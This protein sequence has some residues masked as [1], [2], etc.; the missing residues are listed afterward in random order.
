[1]IEPKN[2]FETKEIS[3]HRCIGDAALA[4]YYQESFIFGNFLENY[5]ERNYGELRRTTEKKLQRGG[6]CLTLS[7]GLRSAEIVPLVSL[8]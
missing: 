3:I 6:G 1:M 4:S 7:P 2:A 8:M 5:G